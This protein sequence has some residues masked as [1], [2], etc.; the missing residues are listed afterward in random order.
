M[1]NRANSK[2]ETGE[3]GDLIVGSFPLSKS[4]ID[5]QLTIHVNN[6]FNCGSG[7]KDYWVIMF[8]DALKSIGNANNAP[9][10]V[11]QIIRFYGIRK[12]RTWFNMVF[13]W[14]FEKAG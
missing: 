13:G 7:G 6:L 12:V 11:E 4:P 5:V 3:G 10:R 14:E 9:D 2:E 8:K 1:F